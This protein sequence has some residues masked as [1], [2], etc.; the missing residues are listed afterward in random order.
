MA[1]TLGRKL[2]WA[3]V[4]GVASKAARSLTR[5]A[6]HHQTGAPRLPT[7]VRHRRGMETALVLAVA[8]GALMAV[9]DVLNEQ[10]KTAARARQPHPA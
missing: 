1:N 5:K 10:G 9:T 7:T 6:M 3:V 8:T 4:G 2:M